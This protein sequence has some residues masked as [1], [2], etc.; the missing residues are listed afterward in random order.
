MLPKLLTDWNA[1]HGPGISSKNTNQRSAKCVQI[2]CQNSIVKSWIKIWIK[3]SSQDK[4]HQLQ[5]KPKNIVDLET[6]K[7]IVY[8]LFCYVVATCIA[9][10]IH[11]V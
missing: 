9:F 5:T 4:S 11:K 3:N 2:I 7:D 10:E 1:L 8:F 6:F